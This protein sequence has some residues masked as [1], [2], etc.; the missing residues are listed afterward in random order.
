MNPA[1]LVAL[2]RGSKSFENS[3]RRGSIGFSLRSIAVGLLL[4]CLCVTTFPNAETIVKDWNPLV[5]IYDDT[6]RYNA[7]DGEQLGDRVYVLRGSGIV[8]SSEDLQDWREEFVPVYGKVSR[9]NSHQGI[10]YASSNSGVYYTKGGTRWDFLPL[11]ENGLGGIDGF[12]EF[13]NWFIQLRKDDTYRVSRDME[14]WIEIEEFPSASNGEI[15]GG[16]GDLLLSYTTTS[17]GE[18]IKDFYIWNKD[19]G[20]LTVPLPKS[21]IVHGVAKNENVNYLWMKPDDSGRDFPELYAT[22]DFENW[23]II[24]YPTTSITGITSI[25]FAGD[26]VVLTGH[27]SGNFVYI[28]NDNMETWV[29]WKLG[30]GNYYWMESVTFRDGVYYSIAGSSR[31]RFFRVSENGLDWKAPSVHNGPSRLDG[32]FIVSSGYVVMGREDENGNPFEMWTSSNL[33]DW[34]KQAGG[35]ATRGNGIED[36]GVGDDGRLVILKGDQVLAIDESGEKVA[37]DRPAIL[38]DSITSSGSSFVAWDSDGYVSQTN[39]GLNWSTKRLTG[40]GGLNFRVFYLP[41]ARKFFAGSFNPQYFVSDDGKNWTTRSTGLTKNYGD[42]PP[43]RVNEF[44]VISHESGFA[45]SREGSNWL[46]VE[47]FVGETMM[48]LDGKYITKKHPDH[49]FSSTYFESY[50]G[51]EWF[52]NSE[53]YVPDGH[54]L[55]DIG[56]GLV[57]YESGSIQRY[58]FTENM[59]DWVA[60]AGGPMALGSIKLISEC[61]YYFNQTSIYKMVSR[62]SESDIEV[63]GVESGIVELEWMW[64]GSSNGQM[65]ISTD[66]ENWVPVEAMPEMGWR[67]TGKSSLEVRDNVSVFARIASGSG[68]N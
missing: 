33:L 6:D 42:A 18:T 12:Y 34:K 64:N 23:E 65:Q 14:N 17:E 53:L 45:F 1:D 13:G 55:L 39:D 30:S 19:E 35:V 16:W 62:M 43:R 59:K 21:G 27:G 63:K 46:E 26:I 48:Y 9:L 20:W 5:S 25:A 57:E 7:L 60:I 32:L 36:F 66:L 67:I 37:I 8:Y 22:S 47:N 56:F 40:A 10:V 4:N 11:V 52:E 41:L 28:S 58:M 3:K 31:G 38:G 51:L 24:D 2:G 54:G 68:R 50:N 49:Q 29:E 61:P 44:L 15:S